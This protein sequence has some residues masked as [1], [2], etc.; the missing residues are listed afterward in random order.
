MVIVLCGAHICVAL[1]PRI[2]AG[3]TLC[4]GDLIQIFFDRDRSAGGRSGG[5]LDGCCRH[6]DKQG[7]M[8]SSM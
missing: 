3:G 7:A 8:P 2:S 1:F 5:I 4:V 6:T